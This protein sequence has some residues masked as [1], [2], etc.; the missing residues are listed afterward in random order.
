MLKKDFNFDLPESLIAKF[1]AE[2]R[3]HSKLLCLNGLLVNETILMQ[4][5]F[6]I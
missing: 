4:N 3:T 2:K 1:P 5:S 6:F